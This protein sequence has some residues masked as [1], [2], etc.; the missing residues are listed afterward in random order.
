MTKTREKYLLIICALVVIVFPFIRFMLVI[1][2][3]YRGAGFIN[4]KCVS[5]NLLTGKLMAKPFNSGCLNISD[6]FLL[7]FCVLSP[8]CGLIYY[9]YAKIDDPAEELGEAWER[10]NYSKE[11]YR[12]ISEANELKK[13]AYKYELTKE[14]IQDEKQLEFMLEKDFV[15]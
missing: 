11:E 5:Y 1:Y 2:Q 3:G 7:A 12:G 8:V 9:Y 6:Y 14:I 15:H 10:M 13:F 4:G